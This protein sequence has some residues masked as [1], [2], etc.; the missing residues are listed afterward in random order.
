M[1]SNVFGV[2]VNV[3]EAGG[4]GEAIDVDGFSRATG[5]GY[6]ADCDGSGDCGPDWY[7]GDGLG[8]C[9]DQ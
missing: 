5:P 8:D 2:G 1:V 6:I 3:D 9:A 4:D 7:V